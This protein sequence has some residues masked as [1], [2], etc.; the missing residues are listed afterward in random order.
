[1]KAFLVVCAL[2]LGLTAMA[3]P[4]DAAGVQLIVRHSVT[5]YA[6]WR[7]AYNSFSAT[8]K[9][10]GVTR[11]S[12]YQSIEDSNDLTVLHDFATLDAARAF[13]ASDELKTAMQT[14][15]VKGMPQIW[16][17]REAP[18]SNGH[19]GKV[20]LFVQHVVANYS[21]WRKVYVGFAP[22]RK[23]LGV[24]GQ[25]VYWRVDNANDVVATHDFASADK[26]RA[27]V[28]SDDLRTA[29]QSAGVK[30]MPQVWYTRR[31]LK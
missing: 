3:A 21:D 2:A 9:K 12:V 27:F 19:E 24:L 30:G 23:K 14:A 13:V 17:T 11:Q 5:D 6:V 8:Q 10:F 22:A 18:G 15:G 25:A 28:A 16:I 29:M 31:V 4:A 1:M 20:R 26:A 7:K